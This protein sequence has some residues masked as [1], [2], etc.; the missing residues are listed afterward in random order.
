MMDHLLSRRLQHLSTFHHE[1]WEF[2]QRVCSNKP[3]LV[4]ARQ[5]I[6]FQGD[7][8]RSV[9][10]ILKGWVGASKNLSDGRWQTLSVFIEGD[11]CN[12]GLGNFDTADHTLRALTDVIVLDIPCEHLD[13]LMLIRPDLGR[14]LRRSS[15]V[16]S[17]IARERVLSLGQRKAK[18]RCA[19]LICELFWRLRANDG[20]KNNEIDFPLTQEEVGSIIGVSTVHANRML[21][22]LRLAGLIEQERKRLTVLDLARLERLALFTPAYLHLDSDNQAESSLMAR[23]GMSSRGTVFQKRGHDLHVS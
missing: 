10:L 1:D 15:L 16:Q 6:L 23:E 8:F 9:P 11:I 13:E 7:V 3:R 12:Y 18:E 4:R 17:A 2:L 21:Q 22:D 19:H 20:A 14:A 5:P